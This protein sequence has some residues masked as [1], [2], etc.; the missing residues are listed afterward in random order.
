M[1]EN[2]WIHV[3]LFP[4]TASKYSAVALNEIQAV[5]LDDQA[6]EAEKPLSAR[7]HGSDR[8]LSYASASE[9]PAF[10]YTAKQREELGDL[11]ERSKGV[12]RSVHHV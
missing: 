12:F 10:P 7:T 5:L 11:L 8:L 6:G 3:E 2:Y 9:T 1:Q 4:E